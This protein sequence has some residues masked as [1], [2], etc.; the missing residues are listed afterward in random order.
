[1]LLSLKDFV[2]LPLVLESEQAPPYLEQSWRGNGGAAAAAPVLTDLFLPS[3]AATD[4]GWGRQAF[5]PARSSQRMMRITL[6]DW[7]N[8]QR[9]KI[10]SANTWSRPRKNSCAAASDGFIDWTACV[11]NQLIERSRC[12]AQIPKQ[13]GFGDFHHFSLHNFPIRDYEYTWRGSL[14]LG[15]QF[16]QESIFPFH[17]SVSGLFAWPRSPV[18][19]MINFY[20]LFPLPS[21]TSSSLGQ[22]VTWLFFTVR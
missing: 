14:R 13:I 4:D 9:L 12:S 2:P 17:K 16:K 20:V 3:S 6:Q 10:P 7:M 15:P 11:R 22:V 1:M 18:C 21:A 8:G 5:S 19:C